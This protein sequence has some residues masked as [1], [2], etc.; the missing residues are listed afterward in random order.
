MDRIARRIGAIAGVAGVAGVVFGRR[1][2]PQLTRWGATD[3]EVARPY[4]GAEVVPEGRRSPTMA[5]TIDATPEQVWPWLVQMGWDRGGWYSWDL[6]DNAGRRSATEV[7]AEWQNLAVGDQLKFW[8][9]GRVMDAYRVAVIEP[10]SFLGLYG[11][12]TLGGRWLDPKQ[13]R[14]SSYMEA[15]WG[16][17]LGELPDG[18]TRL[19]ISGY[20]TFRP[21]WV[22]RFIA[23][24]LLISLS[25]PMQARMMAVLKRN[26]E[27][28]ARAGA[29][30]VPERAA[31]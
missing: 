11:Y 2:R 14:P 17:L 25:W 9:L 27:R 19:V 20:Q 8:A 12:T 24:W 22:E 15:L 30:T 5:V 18:R 7:H 1:V 28:A 31:A 10:N 16:F 6:L 13:P 29:T 4:P 3:E 21:R 23:S 26:I